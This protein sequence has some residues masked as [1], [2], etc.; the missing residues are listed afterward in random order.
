MLGRILQ[1]FVDFFSVDWIHL[2]GTMGLFV[3]TAVFTAFFPGSGYMF[4]FLY[5]FVFRLSLENTLYITIVGTIVIL[6]CSLVPYY[7][8]YY[9]RRSSIFFSKKQ[10]QKAIISFQKNAYQSIQRTR[11]TKLGPFISY[12]AG[13]FGIKKRTFLAL[14]FPSIFLVHFSCVLMGSLLSYSPFLRKMMKPFNPSNW[15]FFILMVIGIFL[16]DYQK[17]RNKC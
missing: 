16:L 7:L 10:H 2:S 6:V 8:G 5:G 11:V 12:L 15:L 4:L 13:F 14:S 17:K 3:T 9:R 1:I